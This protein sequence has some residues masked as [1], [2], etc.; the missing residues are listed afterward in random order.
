VGDNIS[1]SANFS[2]LIED[3]NYE[4][5]FE[6]D[7]ILLRP[8]LTFMM[9]EDTIYIGKV[10]GPNNIIID[11]TYNPKYGASTF[12]LINYKNK[13]YNWQVK[14]II[15]E[16][17]RYVFAIGDQSSNRETEDS[18][19]RSSL[20][21]E[22]NCLFQGFLICNMIQGETHYKELERELIYIDKKVTFDNMFSIDD[23]TGLGVFGKGYFAWELTGTYGFIVE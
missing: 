3:I 15:R 14:I 17:G 5:F 6:I 22:G 7:S 9:F 12:S 2:N 13:Q 16:T 1:I 18:K 10:S 8:V 20:N 23:K 11:S 21:F 19:T 4:R